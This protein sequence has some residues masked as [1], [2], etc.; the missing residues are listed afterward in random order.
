LPGRRLAM[1]AENS[2]SAKNDTF[3]SEKV[4]K[5]DHFPV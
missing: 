4:N 3:F 2:Y 5:V 1:A